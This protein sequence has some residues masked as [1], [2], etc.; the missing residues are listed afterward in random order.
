MRP[1]MQK[2]INVDITA[3]NEYCHWASFYSIIN[4]C[5]TFLHFAPRVV[6]KD[7]NFTKPKFNAL[8]AEVLTI[9]ALS[10]FYLIRAFKE[11]PW[12]STPS[13]DDT[14]DYNIAKSSEQAILD[15]ITIN[16]KEALI[17]ARSNH[18]GVVE[19]KGRIT[20]NAVMALLADIYLWQGKYAECV[21]MCDPII[22]DPQ[23]E[24]VKAEDVLFNVFFIGNSTESIFELQFDSDVQFNHRVTEFYGTNSSGNSN[25]NWVIP[26][27]LMTQGNGCPFKY[28]GSNEIE[29]EHDIRE[30]DFVRQ[31]ADKYCIVKYVGL[32]AEDSSGKSV[33]GSFNKS[34]NWIFYRLS[35]VILMKAE[36]LVQLN[37]SEADLQEALKMVNI[38]Y[39][40]SNPNLESDSLK[41]ENY[42]NV[43]SLEELVLR[44]RERELM[45]EGKRWFDLVRMARRAGTTAPV[46]NFIASNFAGDVSMQISKMSNMEALY[47]PIHQDELTANRALKQNDFYGVAEGS[48]SNNN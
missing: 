7:P 38:T 28:N 36:A 8:K 26:P 32:R 47:L 44:E 21:N 2:I 33:Y 19:T 45:F 17:L 40:R 46:L 9:R 4:N 34:A 35:D 30:K 43:K 31:I 5:N 10:Y 16:L 24:L 42:N 48:N 22:S 23:Y 1:D 20:K 6:D 14:Q 12:I 15:S 37:R 18:G 41:F 13:I 11:V 39:L 29:S 3:T 25:G 27:I